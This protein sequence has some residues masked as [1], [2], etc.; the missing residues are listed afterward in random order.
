VLA[1]VLNGVNND[2]G[3]HLRELLLREAAGKD[4]DAREHLYFLL[5]DSHHSE[6]HDLLH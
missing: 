1:E 6:Q 2:R 5:F 4:A 3:P